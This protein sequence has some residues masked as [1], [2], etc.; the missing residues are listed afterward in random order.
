MSEKRRILWVFISCLLFEEIDSRAVAVNII[1][2]LG[3]QYAVPH[4]LGRV[5][6]C[7]ASKIYVIH[8]ELIMIK[9]KRIM[10]TGLIAA[11]AGLGFGA[12]GAYYYFHQPKIIY[13]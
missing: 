10:L 8:T 2:D 1:S 6:D 4:L 13:A 12:A 7:V 9:G 5:C 11:A 3:C